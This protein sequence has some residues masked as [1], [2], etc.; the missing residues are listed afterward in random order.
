M[1]ISWEVFVTEVCGGVSTGSFNKGLD[2]FMDNRSIKRCSRERAGM[3]PVILCKQ[4]FRMLGMCK[5]KALLS[6]ARLACTAPRVRLARR[7]GHCFAPV[8]LCPQCCALQ[9]H[10]VHPAY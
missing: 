5:Q 2:I 6:V 3:F 10:V 9:G 1:V 4:R 8:D 7:V